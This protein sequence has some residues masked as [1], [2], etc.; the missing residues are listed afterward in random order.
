MTSIR[1]KVARLSWFAYGTFVLLLSLCQYY[2]LFNGYSKNDFSIRHSNGK[3]FVTDFV[4]FYMGGTIARARDNINVYEW[5]S[6]AKVFD[7]LMD[8][9]PTESDFYT[10]SFPCTFVLMAPITYLPLNL[11]HLVWDITTLFFGSVA[12]W[13]L[14]I[15]LDPEHR[16]KNLLIFLGLFYS[17]PAF[18]CLLTG[19]LSWLL[20]G[21]LSAYAYCLMARKQVWA[22]FLLAATTLKPQYMLF[23]SLPPLFAKQFRVIASAAIFEIIYLSLTVFQLGW[24][25]IASYPSVLK[26]AEANCSFFPD[27]MPG[28]RG[29]LTTVVPQETALFIGAAAMVC[30]FWGQIIL[31][32]VKRSVLA[33]N[34]GISAA[35]CVTITASLFFNAHSFPYDSLFLAVPAAFFLQQGV[36]TKTNNGINTLL[37]RVAKVLFI[38]YPFISW[39]CYFVSKL[40]HIPGLALLG[41]LTLVFYLA[42]V[43]KLAKLPLEEILQSEQK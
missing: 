26:H 20:L 40:T 25:S 30:A 2:D 36:E 12:F 17:F 37:G 41:I 27:Q 35:L 13:L 6:Q 29:L 34:A 32:Y 5:A 11:A 9:H 15:Y 18:Q 28:I 7:T 10:Q 19:Q 33:T 21:I 42:S 38:A 3:E 1:Q 23:L 14:L 43:E 24:D 22:G 31:F 39:I 16:Q 8:V 4:V